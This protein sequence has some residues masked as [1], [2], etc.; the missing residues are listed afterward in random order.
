LLIGDANKAKEKLGWEAK[1]TLHD[2]VNDMMQSDIKLMQKET[3][4]KDGG[5]YTKNYFE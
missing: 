5:F 1:H 4:L 3:Y 2:L